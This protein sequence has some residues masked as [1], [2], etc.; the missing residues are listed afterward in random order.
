MDRLPSI[1]VPV[2]SSTMSRR[3]SRFLKFAYIVALH[4]C[5]LD[6]G[7]GETAEDDMVRDFTS[8]PDS[9]RPW[10]W[11]HWLHG[12][13]DKKSITRQLE[14]M[15]RAGLGGM[16]MFDVAQPG[17][18]AGPHQYMQQSWQEMFAHQMKL[19]GSAWK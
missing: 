10:V 18:P 4:S 13:V 3:C 8:P 11:G 17:I 16:T 19:R 9:A 15:K 7:H 14:A 6:L 2:K 5:L 12:N 1:P